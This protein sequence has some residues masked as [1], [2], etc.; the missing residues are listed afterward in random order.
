[1]SGKR[2]IGEHQPSH[3]VGVYYGLFS[4]EREAADGGVW[5]AAT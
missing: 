4:L 2:E 1:M 5:K 3:S